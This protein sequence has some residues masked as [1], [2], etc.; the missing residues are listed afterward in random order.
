MSLIAQSSKPKI[1]KT[2]K[3]GNEKRKSGIENEIDDIENQL[4]K[5]S[6]LLDKEENFY[7]NFQS[8]IVNY[9][10]VSLKP[11]ETK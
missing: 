5:I 4:N 11:T 3:N 7:N 9:D 10:I 1:S 2:L 6:S 8:S